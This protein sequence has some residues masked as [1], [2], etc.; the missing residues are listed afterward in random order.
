MTQGRLIQIVKKRRG[1]IGET[2]IS[3]KFS[4]AKGIRKVS[5]QQ[6]PEWMMD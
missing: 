6:V 5:V 4:L 1:V 3:Y 2:V